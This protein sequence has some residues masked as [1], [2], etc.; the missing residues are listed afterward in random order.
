[1]RLG[2]ELS[3]RGQAARPLTLSF[4]GGPKREKTRRLS[5]PS[6]HADDLRLL[7]YQVMDA[8]GLQRGR[9]TGLAL[10]GEDLVDAVLVAEQLTGGSRWA[11]PVVPSGLGPAAEGVAGG[12]RRQDVLEAV[13]AGRRARDAYRNPIGVPDAIQA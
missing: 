10:R 2:V 7:A 11:R 1:M 6:A 5:E 8:A 9:L 13:T 4:A 12:L 3:C